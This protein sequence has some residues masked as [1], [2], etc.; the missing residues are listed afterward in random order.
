MPGIAMPLP[1]GGPIVGGAPLTT[2]DASTY[3]R[4]KERTG[5]AAQSA[6]KGLRE[7]LASRGL[8]GSGLEAQETAK[9]YSGGLSDLAETDR[10]QAE[11]NTERDFQTR[12]AQKNR[13]Y[14][15]AV[16][17]LHSA[18]AMP[19]GGQGTPGDPYGVIAGNKMAALADAKERLRA[20][21]G[22]SMPLGARLY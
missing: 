7:T 1:A 15:S 11:Q 16:E 13:E 3:G 5:L 20:A 9:V 10:Q 4:A 6:I 18:M 22:Y 12:E 19:E 21:T 8:L 2:A 17:G 14:Q